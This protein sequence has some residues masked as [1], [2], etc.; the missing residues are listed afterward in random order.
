MSP[1]LPN[2]TRR[3]LQVLHLLVEGKTNKEIASELCICQKTV[4]FHL[5]SL[6]SKIKARTRTE[7]VLWAMQKRLVR[8]D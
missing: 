2:L 8:R 5:G 1:E 3:E 4:E 7:A 6:F